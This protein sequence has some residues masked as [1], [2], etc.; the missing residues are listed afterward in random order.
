METSIAIIVQIFIILYSIILHEV[1]HGAVAERLGDDTA[2]HAGRLTLNPIPHIDPIGTILLPLITFFGAGAILGWARGE[3]KVALAGPLTNFMI[4]FFFATLIRFDSAEVLE[5]SNFILGLFT[6]GVLLNVWLALFN[7]IPIPPLDG[8]KVLFLLIDKRNYALRAFLEQYGL[9]L[10]I[11]FLFFGSAFLHP[12]A[13]FF[14]RALV[15]G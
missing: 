9:I 1:A 3:L 10:L 8:S 5:F 13:M 11:A 2:K 7:L 4:A 6:Y 15:G 14:T 12:L